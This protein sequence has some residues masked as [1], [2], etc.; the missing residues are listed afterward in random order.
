MH[1]GVHDDGLIGRGRPSCFAARVL[2]SR[3]QQVFA[4]MELWE[5][6]MTSFGLMDGSMKFLGYVTFGFFHCSGL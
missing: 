2:S 5:T 6:I 3:N 1:I 4:G